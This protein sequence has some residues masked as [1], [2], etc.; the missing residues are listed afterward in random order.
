MYSPFNGKTVL[1]TGGA[2]SIGAGLCSKLC[3]SSVRRIRIVDRDAEALGQLLLALDDPRVEGQILDIC[4]QSSV[5]SAFSG[6]SFAIH[7]AAEKDLPV[8]DERPERAI[9]SNVTGTMNVIEAARRANVEAVVLASSDKAVN[10]ASCL[11]ASKLIAEK[12]FDAARARFPLGPRFSTVRLCNV[13]GTARSVSQV[14]QEQIARGGPVTITDRRMKRHFMT[15]EDAVSLFL[16]A[17]AEGSD[18]DK[19]VPAAPVI[20]I[21]RLARA[22]IRCLAPD[23]GFREED[24]ELV[25]TGRRPSEKLSES[26]MTDEE[27]ETAVMFGRYI[28]INEGRKTANTQRTDFGEELTEDQA[29]KFLFRSG[30]LRPSPAADYA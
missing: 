1:V 24:I 20:G 27:L 15:I 8:C 28:V 23:Y 13:L 18:G 21:A 5:L 3:T 4:D 29:I 30:L 25:F 2:G 7:L 10:A 19:F 22:F 11:G 26:L 6:V 14:F 16:I 17:L 12:L 9:K